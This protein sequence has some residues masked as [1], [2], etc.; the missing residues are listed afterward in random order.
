[1]KNLRVEE[2]VKN[3][4]AE[5]YGTI[6]P[7]DSVTLTDN[8]RTSDVEECLETSAKVRKGYE[9]N[10]KERNQGKN[11]FRKTGKGENGRTSEML[12]VWKHSVC[13][14]RDDCQEYDGFTSSP[15]QL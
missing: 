1:M 6:S 7:R 10:A 4:K 13:D 12:E 2:K 3:K 14:L 5:N 9:R 8:Q 11:K 15:V